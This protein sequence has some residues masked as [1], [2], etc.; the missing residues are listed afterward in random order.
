MNRPTHLVVYYSRSG[1]TR[2]VAEMLATALHADIEE[3]V[4][5]THRKGLFGFLRSIFEAVSKRPAAIARLRHD[6]SA[7]QCVVIGTPVWAGTVSSPVR[8]YLL[9]YGGSLREP[10]LFCTEGGRGADETFAEMQRL[11][12][13]P[14]V[15]QYVATAAEVKAGTHEARLLDFLRDLQKSTPAHPVPAQAA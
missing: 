2:K 9:E 1:T 10:A 7:Y 3:L 6:P 5:N 12:G 13:T 14:A 8:A 4:D 15:A 11:I